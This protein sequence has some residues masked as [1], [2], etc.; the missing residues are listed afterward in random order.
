LTAN[1]PEG[2]DRRAKIMKN[3]NSGIMAKPKIRQGPAGIPTFTPQA[4]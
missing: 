4:E 2:K 3:G 1:I